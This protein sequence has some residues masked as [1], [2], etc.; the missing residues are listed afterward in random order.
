MSC[1]VV[2]YSNPSFQTTFLSL[3]TMIT[4]YCLTKVTIL[5]KNSK[6]IT[7]CSSFRNVSGCQTTTYHLSSFWTFWKQIFLTFRAWEGNNDL[8]LILQRWPYTS[9]K[10]DV[11][12]D[13]LYSSVEALWKC[14]HTSVHSPHLTF[15]AKLK[16]CNIDVVK[17]L[18]IWCP[19]F[20]VAS[21]LP[22]QY[23]MC[24]ARWTVDV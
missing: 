14:Y 17:M 5:R 16:Y 4:Q 18:R 19:H 10:Y 13:C 24:I 15:F 8:N 12:I 1:L 6:N 20:N 9:D 7:R 22:L 2:L 23:L 21:T 11:V 3:M